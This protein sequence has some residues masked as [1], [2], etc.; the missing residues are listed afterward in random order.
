MKHAKEENPIFKKEIAGFLKEN[1]KIKEA[2]DSFN[3][4]E[5]QYIKAM[6]SMEHK[7][8]P[9]TNLLLL[10]WHRHYERWGI[11]VWE[12]QEEINKII[13]TSQQRHSKLDNH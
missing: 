3:I 13:Q 2:L 6:Q 12:I 11:F 8:Q 7:L 10:W 9:Q 4:S 5:E 1:P